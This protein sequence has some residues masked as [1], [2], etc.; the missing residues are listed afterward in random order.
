MVR[1]A[2]ERPLRWGSFPSRDRCL[3]AR[4]AAADDGSVRRR[5]GAGT[6]AVVGSVVGPGV[7][8]AVESQERLDDLG[9]ELP[10]VRLADREEGL[11]QVSGKESLCGGAPGEVGVQS[12]DR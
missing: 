3:R 5:F 10:V 7:G 2:L 4:R 9:A 11:N 8:E 1:R 12:R 6:G